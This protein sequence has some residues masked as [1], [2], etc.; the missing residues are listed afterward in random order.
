MTIT[1]GDARHLYLD[2]MKRCLTNW[3]YG[4]NEWVRAQPEGRVERLLTHMVARRGLFL[5]RKAPFD[6]LKRKGGLDWPPSAH[7]MIGLRRLDNLQKCLEDVITTEIPG[8]FMET[9]V[10]RGG[11]TIFMRAVLKAYNITNRAVWAADSFE[12]LP[13][14]DPEAYP[15]DTGDT[16]H[17]Y[18]ELRVTLD[19]VR[20]NFAAYGL[21]DDQTRFL[22]GWFRDTLP[23]APVERLALLRLDGDMYEST[24]IALENLYPRVSI[25][26]YV[27][28]DDYCIASCAKAVSD[29]RA[30]NGI[31]DEI[32]D[33]DGIGVYWQR[34]T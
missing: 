22:P 12:G 31:K 21:L 18:D 24:M 10:W 34:R 26:G 14:P 19:E 16:H 32:A 11:A 9:G 28:V 5:A 8:D 13:K 1:S 33:I 4:N 23:R 27:I 30:Q 25:G 17:A 20:A 6:P 15:E 29:Y 2:L 7:T 3:V